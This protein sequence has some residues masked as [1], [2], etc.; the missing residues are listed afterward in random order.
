MQH[1]GRTIQAIQELN[2]IY[3]YRDCGAIDGELAQ[4]RAALNLV[5]EFAVEFAAKFTVN[6]F[7]GPFN[8]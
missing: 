5:A 4:F 2:L 6:D 7:R 1:N 8:G 3:G